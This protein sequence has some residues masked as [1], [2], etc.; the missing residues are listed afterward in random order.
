LKNSKDP[1]VDQRHTLKAM[2]PEIHADTSARA[3]CR[4]R[5]GGAILFGFAADA[6][7]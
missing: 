5:A 4:R 7:S 3:S 6:A 2:A 1:E